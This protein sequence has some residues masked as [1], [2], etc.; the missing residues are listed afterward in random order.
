[1]RQGATPRE[2]RAALVAHVLSHLP[3]QNE[4]GSAF[5][6]S[7]LGY[8]LAGALAEHVADRDFETLMHER[9]FAPLC[10][11]GAGFGAPGRPVRRA[12]EPVAVPVSEPRGH[13][14]LFGKALPVEPGVG[15]DNPVLYAPAGTMHFTLE[16]WARFLGAHVA[17]RTSGLL[18]AASWERLHTP[19]AE[20]HDYA[21]GWV[22][23][24]GADGEL[25]LVHA[26]SNTMW[27]ARCVALP[28]RGVALLVVANQAD[29]AGQAATEAALVALESWL[30]A[31]APA[32]ARESDATEGE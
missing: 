8:V 12:D 2:Q 5:S 18:D 1:M 21:F 29:D 24:T 23:T 31:D 14:P 9:L 20:G 4:P 22:R 7:N 32:G 3:P 15:A 10:I 16:G 26:D 30:A 27:F 28:E 17:P 13:R 11:E 25:R 19:L 6:Y